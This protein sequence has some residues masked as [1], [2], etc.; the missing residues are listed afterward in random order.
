[1]SNEEFEPIVAAATFEA[2]LVLV[3]LALDPTAVERNVRKLMR[4]QR[5]AAE[6]E[7]RR[8]ARSAEL[9]AY[10]LELNQKAASL[11]KR[12]AELKESEEALVQQLAER[13]R[14]IGQAA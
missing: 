11:S 6:F 13:E 4:F 3:K 12:E 2:A 9:V 1:V 10:E 7:A 14:R 5:E 8:A